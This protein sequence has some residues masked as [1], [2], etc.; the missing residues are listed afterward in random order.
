[1]KKSR[2]KARSL[3]VSLSFHELSLILG[4]VAETLE[5]KRQ[6]YN[7]TDL[8]RLVRLHR[9]LDLLG[10]GSEPDYAIKAGAVV[11]AVDPTF[12]IA[13][14]QAQRNGWGQLKVS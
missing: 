10:I 13:S 9:R 4:A 11:S 3:R 12:V 1:M 2:S 7:R 5:E 14:P 6:P 8:A